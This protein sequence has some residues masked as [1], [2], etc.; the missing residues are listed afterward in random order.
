MATDWHII[1]SLFQSPGHR[2]IRTLWALIGIL[3]M[4]SVPSAQAETGSPSQKRGNEAAAATLNAGILSQADI[5]R[6]KKIFKVQE[7][8]DWR[9][10]DQL[11][12]SLENDILMGHVLHQRYLHPT[13]YRSKYNELRDWMKN[14]ADHP[15]AYRIYRL[16][17]KRRPKGARRPAR[18]V[19]TVYRKTVNEAAA[20]KSPRKRTKTVRRINR[21][22]KSLVRRERPTQAYKYLHERDTRKYL[23]QNEMDDARAW[24]AASYYIEGVD[25]KAFPIAEDVANRNR[26]EVPIADWTAGL[27]AWRLGKFDKAFHHFSHL[28]KARS[29]GKESRAAGAFWAARAALVGGEPAAVKEYLEL[30]AEQPRTFYGVLASRQL[31]KDLPLDWTEPKASSQEVAAVLSLPSVKRAVALAEVGM[32]DTADQE[33]RR[34]HGRMSSRN[35][36]ALLVV[37]RAHNLP[38]A[39]VQIAEAISDEG[40]DAARYPLPDFQPASGFTLD[41]ALV[42]A[43]MRQESRFKA[44]AKSHAGA[45]GLMQIMPRTASHVARDRSLA[46]SNK[47]KLLDPGFNMDLGQ[48][49]IRQ[50]MSSSKMNTN[51]FLIAVAYNGG[52]GNLNRWRKKADYRNDPLLFIE[53]IPSRETRGYVEKVL[54]NLW[55]YRERLG[56]EAPSLDQAAGNRWPLYVSHDN[57]RSP[58]AAN[59]TK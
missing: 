50:L 39:Q 34:V 28:S 15:D 26:F 6:Y 58:V 27:A 10:A 20:L 55:I 19:K 13:A 56:Q 14:H 22:I 29:A 23:G 8:G 3:A 45:R 53:S 43:F 18:P 9:Q 37:A 2:T 44:K 57:R 46:R 31:G 24:I 32:I 47:D 52:P 51:L 30:A 41:R 49:Y 33:L 16:A 38:A 11:I 42:Y 1:T 4:L 54:T 25:D 40:L 36:K 12:R 35:D 21:K 5:D 7:Q 59:F 48:K 17:T